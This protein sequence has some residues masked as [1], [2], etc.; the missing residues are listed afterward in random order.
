MGQRV[1]ADNWS[2]Q[3]VSQL[4][5]E[6]V[7]PGDN[8]GIGPLTDPGQ[9]AAPLPQAAIDIEALFDLLSDVVL[10]GQ[11]LV[12]ENFKDAW[13]GTSDALGELARRSIVR[14]HSFL[15]NP[16][17]LEAPRAEFLKSLLLNDAMLKEHAAN[18][19]AWAKSRTTP[20]QF[21]SQLVWGGAGM[22]ARAWVYETS[23]TPHP[24]RRRLFQRAGVVLPAPPT[25]LGEFKRDVARHRDLLYTTSAN[26]DAVSGMHIVLPA[27]P[28]LIL[29]DA[30]SLSEMFVVASQMRDQLSELRAWLSQ[31][32]EA[33]ST[34]DFKDISRERER[35]RALE[36]EVERALGKKS[37]DAP[38]LNVG[39]SWLRVTHKLDLGKWMPKKDMVQV[40]ASTV[41]FAPS[42]HRELRKLLAFFG[43]ERSA[44]GVKVIKHFASRGL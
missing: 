7:D 6:G 37:A 29:R 40:Q 17:R 9:D 8:F 26:H 41:T 19:A 13:F 20:H 18:E 4:L 10:R 21:T 2:L 44:T 14:P 16:E 15:Q 30:N 32:Q 12:D 28:A 34:G 24:L 23:Y 22:L 1:I 36:K 38:T 5:K 31:F 35:L 11:I 43:H 27:I 39:V 3:A 42:G 33:I 25:A